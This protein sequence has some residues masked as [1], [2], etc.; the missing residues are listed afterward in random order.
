MSAITKNNYSNLSTFNENNYN[1][2]K[3]N[4]GN[5]DFDDYQCNYED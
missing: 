3:I 1:P 2:T 4:Y 5:T